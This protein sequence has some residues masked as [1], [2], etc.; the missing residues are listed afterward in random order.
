MAGSDLIYNSNYYVNE[1]Q[2]IIHYQGR[3][4]E[5]RVIIPNYDFLLLAV[6]T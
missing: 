6:H 1:R 4:T 5:E 3:S 2:I